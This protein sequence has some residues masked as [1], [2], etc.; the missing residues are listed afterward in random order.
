VAVASVLFADHQLI[1]GVYPSD[2]PILSLPYNPPALG[3]V[4]RLEVAQVE[5]LGFDGCAF[6]SAGAGVSNEHVGA[7]PAGDRHEAG[8]GAAGGEP[9]VGGCVPKSVGPEPVDPGALGAA[10]EGT[11]EPLA[12]EPLTAVT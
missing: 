3:L 4:A 11:T 9:A 8:F 5:T 10:A 2:N 6:G 1:M 7:G 12:P